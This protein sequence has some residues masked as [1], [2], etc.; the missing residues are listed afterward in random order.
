MAE[1]KSGK[2]KREEDT[3][4]ELEIDSPGSELNSATE[5][6]TPVT[7]IIASC[8]HTGHLRV[9][10]G[11]DH[12]VEYPSVYVNQ[13]SFSELKA[14][15]EYYR[16]SNKTTETDGHLRCTGVKAKGDGYVQ[17]TI[18]FDHSRE[19]VIKK[20]AFELRDKIV[21]LERTQTDSNIAPVLTEGDLVIRRMS[22][23]EKKNYV[24]HTTSQSISVH[25]NKELWHRICW[26]YWNFP[27]I[28]EEGLHIGH[29]CQ[30]RDC[31]AKLHLIKCSKDLNE[32]QKFCRYYYYLNPINNEPIFFLYC[33]HTPKCSPPKIA[34]LL[35]PL[36]DVN[37]ADFECKASIKVGN[38]L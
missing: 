37:Q 2:R 27:D 6:T 20:K 36:N 28:I 23:T 16:N 26:R 15:V 3:D 25:K 9:P 30:V 13:M 1:K 12:M 38:L 8:V 19:Q 11:S 7:D 24:S 35:T 21:A 34:Y 17:V 4:A 18:K 32:Q 10:V 22:V 5:A 14:T 29:T 33:P 31:G